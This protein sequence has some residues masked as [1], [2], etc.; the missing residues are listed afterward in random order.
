M[1]K[2]GNDC[3][4]F[5]SFAFGISRQTTYTFIDGIRNGTY[6]KVGSYS[7]D[8]P[9]YSELISS[10]PLMQSGDAITNTGHSILIAGNYSDWCICYEQTPPQVAYTYYDHTQLANQSY[11]PFS[12]K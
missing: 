11:I 3:S 6:P 1:P 10:Y 7:V 2:Y 8:S 12:K 9:A 5:V 4:A